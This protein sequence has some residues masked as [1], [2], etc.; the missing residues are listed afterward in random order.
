[1]YQAVVCSEKIKVGRGK[2][3]IVTGWTPVD[4]VEKKIDSSMY[5]AIGTLYNPHTSID[6]LLINLF[7]NPQVSEIIAIAAT[8]QDENA[9]SIEVLA[10]LWRD[11]LDESSSFEGRVNITG[12]NG[13][14][15]EIFPQDAIDRLRYSL[16]ITVVNS[17]DSARQ[18]LVCCRKLSPWGTTSM[19]FELPEVK[20]DS[21]PASIIG[22]QVLG[23]NIPTVWSEALNRI[24]TT[25]KLVPCESG[26]RVELLNFSAV[27][28]HSTALDEIPTWLPDYKSD[29]ARYSADMVQQLDCETARSWAEPKWSDCRGRVCAG[30]PRTPLVQERS[31]A[32]YTYTY[33]MRMRQHFEIDQIEAA[34]NK[35]TDNINTTQCVINLWDSTKDIGI[36]FPP[37]LNHIWLRAV[38]DDNDYR[39]DLT[40]TFRSHDIYK[41]WI[42]N[43]YALQY[44]QN[45]I[46]DRLPNDVRSGNL[47]INSLSAHIYLEDLPRARSYSDR[48]LSGRKYHPRYDDPVGNYLIET[49][50]STQSIIVTR[51]DKLAQPIRTYNS[52]NVIA[53]L[54]QIIG[55]A[56]TIT[57]FHSAYLGRELQRAK[58]AIL[59]ETSYEQQ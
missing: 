46:C 56:P 31:G 25:G 36:D 3:V 30:D 33:G 11:G 29:I 28:R 26:S 16:P 59:A 49:N 27:V 47:I 14:I 13:T 17:I 1:M 53:L 4:R 35:L 34:I 48:S 43:T 6:Y 58:Q 21:L 38:P 55:D 2:A 5:A 18:L 52:R 40:A 10:N 54:E 8:P 7:N 44:L 12:G 41:A 42:K 39:L 9:R 37:C 19:H 51:Q 57:P 45:Y 23:D 32:S 20:V 50:G 22:Q 24:A 15:S